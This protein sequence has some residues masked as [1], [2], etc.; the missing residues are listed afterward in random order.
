M[1]QANRALTNR[2]HS[3]AADYLV[4]FQHGGRDLRSGKID[5]VVTG[6][7]MTDNV[8]HVGTKSHWDAQKET[9]STKGA[10]KKYDCERSGEFRG[11]P[12]KPP[13]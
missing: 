5:G 1:L 3:V 2:T 4:P 6:T 11:L 8:M 9:E 10:R 12:R 13:S 7:E